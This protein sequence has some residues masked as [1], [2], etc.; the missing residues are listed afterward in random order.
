[1]GDDHG[2]SSAFSQVWTG[3]T[4][5]SSRTRSVSNIPL[6]PVVMETGRPRYTGS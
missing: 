5:D 3:D 1:M 4:V 2:G 6:I